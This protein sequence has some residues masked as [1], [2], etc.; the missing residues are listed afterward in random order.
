MEDDT[1][2][3]VIRIC[4]ERGSRAYLV[5][6]KRKLKDCLRVRKEEGMNFF[7]CFVGS[8]IWRDDLGCGKSCNIILK[9]RAMK[10]FFPRMSKIHLSQKSDD[11]MGVSWI[12]TQD[13][14]TV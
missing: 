6:R 1:P 8:G 12:S 14:D 2:A 3:Y 13:R 10:Y 11:K 5:K 4:R 7:S 9:A